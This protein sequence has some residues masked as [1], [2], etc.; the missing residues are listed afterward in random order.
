MALRRFLVIN[1]DCTNSDPNKDRMGCRKRGMVDAVFTAPKMFTGRQ[2][3]LPKFVIVEC[4]LTDEELDS[5]HG[6]R[7]VW[8]DDLDYEVLPSSQPAQGVYDVRVFE[9]N[10]GAI[11]QN[12][13]VGVKATRIRDYL[14]AWGCSNFSLSA[15][16]ASFTFSLWDAVRS[17]NFWGV[18]AL[19]L[20]GYSF[21]LNSF[22]PD[23]GIGNITVTLP[24][25]TEPE[26][27]NRQV[28]QATRRI[29]E[30][31]GTVVSVNYPAITFTLERN[32]ILTKFRADVKKRVQQVYMY[33]QH[34]FNQTIMDAAGAAGGTITLTKA[35]LLA[36][37]RDLATEV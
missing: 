7:K 32:N 5:I 11:N 20:A 8:Q 36:G 29:E 19:V 9:L 35:E 27:I 22:D 24:L 10:P 28:L 16:D 1:F 31:G 17:P 25:E 23:Q 13:I 4:D 37:I 3:K 12:A 30:R 33:Q 14:I 34:R 18:S 15:T 21:Q 6:M 26:V 2:E